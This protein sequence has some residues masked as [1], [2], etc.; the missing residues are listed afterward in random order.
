MKQLL[1][2]LFMFV[3]TAAAAG[4]PEPEYTKVDKTYRYRVYFTDK[5]HNNYSTRH[6]EEFLSPQ[7][8]ERRKK[9]KVKVDKYDLP[10]TQ[11]YLEYLSK[12]D[13]KVIN[14]SK[15]NNTAVV[16]VADSMKIEKLKEVAFIKATKKVWESPDSLLIQGQN[17]RRADIENRRDTLTS[18]Y[19]KSEHQIKM[20][21][22]ER[23][24]NQGMKGNGV[25]IA[26][27][28]G[29]FYNADLVSGLKDCR[30]LGTRNFVNPSKS[31]YEE[32]QQHGTM[33]LSCMAA[34]LPY[35]L[36]GSAPEANYYL[37][38]SE[39]NDSEHLIEEDNWCT[40]VEYADSLGADIVTSSLG[41]H[42]F[43][44]PQAS[45]HYYE[46]DGETAINS[47]SAS[48]AASRG[49]LIVNSAGNE[50]DTHWKK[51]GFPADAKDIFTVGA[52]NAQRKN[53]LFSSLGNTADGRTK[54]EVMAQGQATALIDFQGNVTT[55][56]GTS[57]SAP[58]FCGA[59][60][61]L[62]QAYPQA[63]PKEVIEAVLQAGD[64][65]AHPDNVFGYGIPDMY[66]AYEFLKNK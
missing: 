62:I 48:L 58:L 20:L 50:G 12:N 11:L 38:I 60:A 39:D 4:N 33:V 22:V 61:C 18:Y 35:G 24:H 9:F 25:T 5:K 41:Y 15:W 26:V 40:A 37:L 45:H 2:L 32:P 34:L 10:V 21:A 8:L 3:F 66:K 56:N 42:F 27:V 30:I 47:R 14:V 44:D 43:D 46:M 65:A 16:E 51:L 53:T 64:N 1:P 28:D 49:L 17:N 57:F 52:V 13:Y 19:G 6:P 63:K 54:P 36:V 23:L 7:A 59:L 29:G 55:A 31:V